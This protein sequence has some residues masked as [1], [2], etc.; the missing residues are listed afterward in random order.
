MTSVFALQIDRCAFWLML[1][2]ATCSLC[3]ALKHSCEGRGNC[4][5]LSAA[6]APVSRVR[7]IMYLAGECRPLGRQFKNR[8]SGECVSR[9]EIPGCPPYTREADAVFVLQLAEVLFRPV[10]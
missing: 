9:E 1:Q 8:T 3:H 4:I 7:S 2:F 10:F 5:I 6:R